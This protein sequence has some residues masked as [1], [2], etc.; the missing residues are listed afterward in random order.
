MSIEAVEVNILV[1]AN[2]TC[3]CGAL[4]EEV[5]AR[6]GGQRAD[7]LVLA[8]ALNSRLRH[9]VSDTDRAVA[10]AEERLELAIAELG[11]LGL[12]ARGEVGDAD[13][14]QAIDDALA[15]FRAHELII[16]THPEEHSSWLERDLLGRARERFELPIT[17][18]ISE[19]G[20][21]AKL[22]G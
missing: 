2:K 14:I 20:V 5:A 1:V 11:L 6:A 22:A 13:P 7:V 8:P 9:W 4:H 10:E 18:V 19:Y 16:S 15:G 12:S 21:P 17:H 3:P